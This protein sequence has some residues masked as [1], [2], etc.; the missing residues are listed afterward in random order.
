M[1][2]WPT[3]DLRQARQARRNRLG[4]WGDGQCRLPSK[5]FLGDVFER[6]ADVLAL[7]FAQNLFGVD[8]KVVSELS[9][10]GTD[11]DRLPAIGETLLVASK[12]VG[13]PVMSFSLLALSRSAGL[14]TKPSGSLLGRS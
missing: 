5:Q 12:N 3:R 9:K 10:R 6:R 13:S 4:L 14:T 8:L 11:L 1:R 7:K 2:I